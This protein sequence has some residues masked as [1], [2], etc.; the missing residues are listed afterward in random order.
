M[1]L[2][3][4]LSLSLAIM[5]LTLIMLASSAHANEYQT[6]VGDEI[7][8]LLP[9]EAELNQNYQI[10]RQGR[11]ILPEVGAVQ[12]VNQT[13][14]QLAETVR[15]A[16]SA[17]FRDLTNLQVFI[18]K[19]QLLISIQGYVNQPGE[20]TL[21]ANSTVQ[22]ALHA[23]SGLRAGAQLDKLQLQR[24][25][26]TNIFNYKAFLDSGDMSLLPELK[27]LDVLF[28]PASPI[29]G[30][31]EQ[32]FNPL[33]L[34]DGGDAADD[35]GAVKV[36]GEVNRPGS[37]SYKEGVTLV[38]LLMRAG[39][40]TRYAGVEQIRVIADNEPTI[41]NLKGY[42]DSGNEKLLPNI[43]AGTTI[44]VPI[45]VEEVKSGANTV[46]I[47][48]E[49]DKPGAFENKAGTTFMDILANAG[50]PTRFAESRQIRVIKAD[51]T[52]K[53]FDL[54]GYTEG[55]VVQEMP[56]IAA[57]DAIFVPEKTDMNEKSWLKIAPNRAVRVFGE[58]VAPGRIEWSAEM[59]LLELLAHVGG[60]N[61]KADTANIEIL[62]PDD[63]GNITRTQFNLDTFMKEGQ[64]D[65][66]LPFIK[67][68]ST[69]RVSNLP[70][71][72]SDNKSQ[73]VRQSSDSSIYVFGQVGAPGRYRFT[74]ELHFLDILAAADG[75][76]GSAD[77]HNIR[78]TH[79]SDGHARVSQLNL[80]RYFDTGDE[81]LLPIVKPGD[82]IFVPEKDK[83]WLDEPSARTVK[84]LG[85][86]NRP[87]RYR[88][89]DTMTLLDV[90]AEAGGT[91][92][93]AYIEKITVVNMSCCADQATSFN[94]LK[95]AKT[96]NY[97]M[98]PVL[99]AGDTVFVPEKSETFFE[100]FQDSLQVILGIA[101]LGAL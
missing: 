73:W 21:P 54:A 37:F 34:A 74:E 3:R 55:T 95:F 78:I 60:P 10:D 96:G 99:R 93:N 90:L 26:E 40:V 56:T 86:V 23:A 100:Y 89:D 38:D 61:P 39:G 18:N 19:R 8:I 98:L 87:G 80:N 94:L 85:A 77:L 97:R 1:N 71:D 53:S 81:S 31:V 67:A 29:M 5:M 25:G 75:P 28:I 65:S 9:G 76:T 88:F 51:G 47:M 16:L 13:E 17:I 7:K 79:R 30:N 14:Q 58:V 72:P 70:D 41:F 48:G 66:A 27:P 91:N 63:N 45:Q 35:V 43:H 62:T 101:V 83:Q 82:T 33:N 24:N 49:V 92:S 6:Q 50:G 12:V 15:L 69:I 68:G 11:I 84:V 2:C 52:I 20:F 42:L 32:T 22:T 57:G 44:F 59:N 64:P 46:Y 4:N 36:F